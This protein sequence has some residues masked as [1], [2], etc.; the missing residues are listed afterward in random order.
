MSFLRLNALLPTYNSFER[1]MLIVS[2]AFKLFV[3]TYDAGTISSRI[4]RK[5]EVDRKSIV[6]LQT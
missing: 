2:N 4:M 6:D 3:L 1:I 5:I